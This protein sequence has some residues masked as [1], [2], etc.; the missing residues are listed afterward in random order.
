M[1]RFRVAEILRER[2]MSLAD[3]HR[4]IITTAPPSH[5]EQG[6]ITYRTI[7]RIVHNRTSNPAYATLEAIARALGV[8][9]R[10]LL[11]EETGAGASTSHPA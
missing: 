7:H 3:L 5:P 4:R 11:E 6:R 2:G 8:E 9:V 1:A 10:D